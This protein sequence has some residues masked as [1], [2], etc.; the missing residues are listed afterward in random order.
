M[1][2]LIYDK[3]P[4]PACDFVVEGDYPDGD[5]EASSG[6]GS[7]SNS[8]SSGLESRDEALG[9]RGHDEEEGSTRN[10]HLVT[11]QQRDQDDS[12]TDERLQ[13]F[14][15]SCV[16]ASI[17]LSTRTFG[18][19]GSLTYDSTG[20]VAIGRVLGFITCNAQGQVSHDGPFRSLR[21]HYL[22]VIDQILASLTAGLIFREGLLLPFLAHLEL[23]RH[24][25]A[26]TEMAREETDFFIE[27][28]DPH[29]ANFLFAE[30]QIT[31]IV[32][33]VG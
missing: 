12:V 33:W 28:P 3:M 21:E 8:G 7:E 18:A 1:S 17:Q 10:A 26:N 20:D 2:Y 16:A 24:V 27:H 25:Q 29:D 13:Q 30:G 32:D 15:D 6:L 4:G 22:A 23:R 5:N 9:H 31:A 14:I 19:I 11:R